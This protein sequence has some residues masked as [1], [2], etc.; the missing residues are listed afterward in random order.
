VRLPALISARD[1]PGSLWAN[2]ARK[3][4]ADRV[5]DRSSKVNLPFS[6]AVVA[7]GG[8]V[9]RTVDRSDRGGQLLNL[10][11]VGRRENGPLRMEFWALLR[12]RRPS[13]GCR[14]RA[15][16][17]RVIPMGVWKVPGGITRPLDSPT[18]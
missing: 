16:P 17:A 11:M 13:S 7:T 1:G 14:F 15:T 4:S 2:Q 5:E 18:Q 9:G 10:A 8:G 12:R 6:G 3:L